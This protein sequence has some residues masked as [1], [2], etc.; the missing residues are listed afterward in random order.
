MKMNSII[1]ATTGNIIS[2][3]AGTAITWASPE[4]EKLKSSTMAV[5]DGQGSWVNS[6][7]LL[8]A[9]FG[10]F[11]F[12][13]LA[14]KIGRKKTLVSMGCPMAMG[15]VV[16]ALVK[17][18]QVFYAARF[19]IG[20]AVGGLFTVMPM[21]IGEI[22]D[23][24]NRGTLSGILN[25][26]LCMGMLFSYCVGPYVDILTFNLILGVIPAIFMPLF[27]L[28]SVESPRYL[29]GKNE[30]DEAKKN[31]RW[32]KGN[33]DDVN[34]EIA[35]I[36]KAISEEGNGGIGDL[37][38]SSGNVRALI[39]ASGL[40]FFQQFSGINAVLSNAQN[41]FKQAKTPVDA[42][43]CSMLVGA[44][45]LISSGLSMV[46][47]DRLGRKLLLLGSGLGVVLSEVPLGVYSVLRDRDIDVGSISFLP[48]VSL[49]VFILTYNVGLGS[50]PWTV[51]GELYPSNIKSIGSS[52]TASFCWMLGFLIVYFFNSLIERFGLG[53]C[54]FIFSACSACSVLFVQ[55]YCIETKGKTLEEIQKEL[56]A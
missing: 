55:F 7:F 52:V 17:V 40:I 48:I 34:T 47:I 51:M 30:I 33:D 4:I 25:I 43:V 11:L 31:L 27:S 12:G 54:F 41:I 6:L 24:S 45:Q 10:P 42:S 38:K 53:T 16:M 49:V 14:D 5:S 37:F 18:V 32:L 2:F 28:F 50:L 35:A 22:A 13:Y 26:L 44:V 23:S 20:L 21:Y 3:S 1:A 29:I 39:I 46:L 8:G 56:N 36:E 9:S 19:V 15:F